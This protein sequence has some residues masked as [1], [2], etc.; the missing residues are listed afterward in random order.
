[1]S[2]VIKNLGTNHKVSKK[3]AQ[4]EYEEYLNDPLTFSLDEILQTLGPR[5]EKIR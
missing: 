5:N 1:M 3:E 2:E 4:K